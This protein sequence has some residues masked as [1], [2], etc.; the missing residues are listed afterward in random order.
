MRSNYPAITRLP[1]QDSLDRSI[2]N[3]SGHG[4]ST[5]QII[6]DLKHSNAALSAKTAEMEANFMNQ[7]NKLTLSFQEKQKVLEESIKRKDIQLA[8][9]ETR[10]VSTENRI[11]ERDTQLAKLKEE[12]AFQRHS[13]SDLKNQLYQLQHDIEEAEFDKRDE[14]GKWA[15]EQKDMARELETLKKKADDGQRLR[16]EVETLRMELAKVKAFDTPGKSD[17]MDLHESWRQIEEYQDELL[18]S[19]TRLQETQSALTALEE[20]SIRVSRERQHEVD[21]LKRAHAESAAV[22]K[23]KE[24]DLLAK[25]SCMQNSQVGEDLQTKINERDETIFSLR[26]EVDKYSN[27]VKQLTKDIAKIRSEAE[28]REQYRMDEAEDLRVLHDAQEEEITRLRKEVEDALREIEMRDQ[29][30]EEKERALRQIK[31][32]TPDGRESDKDNSKNEVD[33]SVVELKSLLQKSHEVIEKLKEEMSQKSAEHEKVVSSLREDIGKLTAQRDDAE[34]RLLSVTDE[35]DQTPRDL[36]GGETNGDDSRFHDRL[37]EVFATAAK[38]RSELEQD[39]KAKLADVEAANRGV[40]QTME[41]E[42][43]KKDEILLELQTKAEKM[44]K[45]ESE[46]ESLKADKRKGDEKIGLL[47]EQLVDAENQL[48]STSDKALEESRQ[49]IQRLKETIRTLET[50]NLSSMKAKKQLREAQIA[51]VALD[52]DKKKQVMKFR[53]QISSLRKEKEEIEREL[54]AQI[55]AIDNEVSGLK[56]SNSSDNASIVAELVAELDALRSERHYRNDISQEDSVLDELLAS[57]ENEK[58]LANELEAMKQDMDAKDVELQEK[59]N[60]RDTTI[61]A[62]VK[63]SIAQ[64]QKLM[65]LKSELSTIRSELDRNG[66]TEVELEAVRAA[67]AADNVEE[68]EELRSALVDYKQVEAR[69]SREIALLRKERDAAEK[70]AR[71]LKELSKGKFANGAHRHDHQREIDEINTESEEKLRERDSAIANLVKQSVAQEEQVAKFQ[72]QIASLTNE[73]EALRAE[74]EML[75]KRGKGKNS[76]PSWEE[77]RRLRKESEI[78]AGQIIEQDEEM[79]SLK[80]ELRKRDEQI[81]TL[82]RELGALRK[83]TNTIDRDLQAELN[84]LQEA[85]ESKRNELRELRRQLRESKAGVDDVADLRIELEQA[86]H[87]L[88]EYRKKT[89]QGEESLK[90][91]LEAERAS[92]IALENKMQQQLDS[93]RR[94]RNN[95]VEA[96]EAKLKERDELIEAMKTS[97]QSHGEKVESLRDEIEN[98]RHELATKADAL[99]S[100]QSLAQELLK[101]HEELSEMTDQ[102]KNDVEKESLTKQ[103]KELKE[104]L[105]SLSD[106]R[107]KIAELTEKVSKSEQARRASEESLIE[108]YEKKIQALKMNKDDTIDELCNELA[109]AKGKSSEEMDLLKRRLTQLEMENRD[110]KDEL[111]AKLQHKNTRIQA[112]EQTLSAQ[113]QLVENMRS[114]MDHLQ[115]SMEHAT[116]SRRAE[117]EEMHQE[118]IDSSSRVAK[119]EREITTLKMQLEEA[120]LERKAE[121]AKLKDIIASNENPSPLARSVAEHQVDVRM[122]EVKERLEQLKWRNTSLQEENTKLR[123]RLEKAE[124]EVKSSKNAKFRTATLEEQVGTLSK[125]VQELE[126][127]LTNAANEVMA[128]SA[129]S[130]PREANGSKPPIAPA[131]SRQSTSGLERPS[132]E[133]IAT[134]KTHSASPRRGMQNVGSFRFLKRRS[135]SR[136]SNDDDQSKDSK[137]TF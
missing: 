96:L 75:E 13:I 43:Q 62:L 9:M 39:F 82:S 87:A 131:S 42:L 59:L 23:R 36:I 10:C 14:V 136:D 57:R 35:R 45:I 41:K 86:K 70:E 2:H 85:N 123:S 128:A 63:S 135:H 133:N 34:S 137:L 66:G 130:S 8:S 119:Q 100:A 113:L 48:Q 111:E 69:L 91:E 61:S 72:N 68:L 92:K 98:L 21:R 79:E 83:K 78:F 90:L 18:D 126:I 105:E 109:E 81:A 110:I 84:E 33:E 101:K 95:S 99:E 132:P 114:E 56:N 116:L 121:V 120:K 94:L 5:E 80:V 32:Q 25:I 4:K 60:D 88:D 16:E 134:R 19:K 55:L 6:R 117:I 54:R 106:H 46:L 76:G 65:S 125:R 15:M 17:M 44:E 104:Q 74:N 97:N 89:S 129:T 24:S 127:E 77:V 28:T 112:L 108:A 38:E 11:R 53:D 50:K 37:E 22:W 29:E 51:L 47:Q 49:E 103:V 31:T 107:A 58:R 27:Q 71:R 73:L 12:N 93:V 67:R 3:E 124:S 115:G 1:S 7:L 52:D 118:V 30:L 102:L 40:I 20:E 26:A 122:G 64:E